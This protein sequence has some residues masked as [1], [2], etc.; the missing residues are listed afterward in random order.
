MQH[1]E[2]I[3]LDSSQSSITFSSIPQDYDDLV[4]L[5]STRNDST[6]TAAYLYPNGST[7]D[8]TTISLQ[9]FGT[10][11]NSAVRSFQWQTA[12]S[13]QTA[14]TFGNGSI[15]ISN[16]TAS[17]NKS[18]STDAVNENNGSSAV[19]IVNASLWSDTS[20]ITSLELAS[21][22]NFVANSTFYLYGVTAGGDG[23]VTTS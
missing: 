3:E 16:Y 20:A 6:S 5:V 21:A 17:Q 14:N 18:I 7:T 8:M 2:T 11:V 10:G 12:T 1:I 19:A 22:S 23:T 13:A 9:G 15:Y 4:V